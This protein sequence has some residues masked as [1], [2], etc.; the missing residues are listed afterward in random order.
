M[1]NA[2]TAAEV[3]HQESAGDGETDDEDADDARRFTI[4]D[5]IGGKF[6]S[7]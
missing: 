2:E 6:Q 5:G 1:M 4:A 7:H 3:A